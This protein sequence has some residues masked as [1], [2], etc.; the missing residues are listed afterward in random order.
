MNQLNHTYSW[1]KLGV[2]CCVNPSYDGVVCNVCVG[3][4]VVPPGTHILEYRYLITSHMFED[5]APNFRRFPNVHVR[6]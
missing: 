2:K 3:A 6:S 1:L 4:V 5:N